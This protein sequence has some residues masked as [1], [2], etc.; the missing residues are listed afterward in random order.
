MRR[1][2]AASGDPLMRIGWLFTTSSCELGD[3]R[4]DDVW[5]ADSHGSDSVSV[6][7]DV[8]ICGPRRDAGRRRRLDREELTRPRRSKTEPFRGNH[9]LPVLF[10]NNEERLVPIWSLDAGG[11][12]LTPRRD[13]E[14]AATRN[15]MGKEHLREEDGIR[16]PG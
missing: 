11:V 1:S 4:L 16:A 5:H 3:V 9:G 12:H 8:V 7:L 14:R 15:Q 6:E 13:A 10:V 2:A